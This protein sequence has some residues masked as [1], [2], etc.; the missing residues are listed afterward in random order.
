MKMPKVVLD[1]RVEKTHLASLH[2]YFTSEGLQ[3]SRSALGHKITETLYEILLANGKIRSHTDTSADHY[4]QMN[5]V[6]K[7]K[8]DISDITLS[9]RKTLIDPKPEDVQEALE[10]LQGKSEKN[11]NN[12]EQGRRR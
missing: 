3:L 1:T 5:M 6:N 7:K 12:P 8:V 2:E 4:F 10:R 11:P 9:N